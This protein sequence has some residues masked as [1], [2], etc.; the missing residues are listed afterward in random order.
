MMNVPDMIDA[1]QNGPVSIAVSAGNDC[2]RYY[3]SGVLTAANNCPKNLDHGVVVVGL[4][5]ADGKDSDPESESED[6]PEPESE[7]S[8]SSDTES[9]SS[10]S[11]PEP[12]DSDSE[13]DH[14]IYDEETHVHR[15][16]KK[17]TA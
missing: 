1:I 13:S 12:I 6:E 16:C 15:R 10:D 8:E 3:K 7:S 14:E 17:T 4:H 2:W 9:E 11:D 5:V